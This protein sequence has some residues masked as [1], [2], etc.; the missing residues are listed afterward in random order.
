MTGWKGFS[1]G[2]HEIVAVYSV[3]SEI[4]D[5]GTASVTGAVTPA[6]AA[7]AIVVAVA[8]KTAVITPELAPFVSLDEPAIVN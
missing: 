2:A 6:I 7:V 5:V 1:I 3:V 4:V 8:G